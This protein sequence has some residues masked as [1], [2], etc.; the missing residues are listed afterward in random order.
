[1][2]HEIKLM[3]EST[4]KKIAITQFKTNQQMAGRYTLFLVE[5]IDQTNL[6]ITNG[7]SQY[8][9]GTYILSLGDYRI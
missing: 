8:Y 9:R 7:K 3:I 2:G 6:L 1:M 5:G 4:F